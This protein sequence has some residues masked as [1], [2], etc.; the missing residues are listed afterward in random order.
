MK[1]LL[2]DC[3]LKMYK[4]RQQKKNTRFLGAQFSNS[5]N[6]QLLQYVGRES[7]EWMC[8]LP[9]MPRPPFHNLK[10][11]AHAQWPDYFLTVYGQ[12]GSS[13]SG[14]LFYN[15]C[16]GIGSNR[17]T[18]LLVGQRGPHM[19]AANQQDVKKNDAQISLFPAEIVPWNCTD[20]HTTILK[21]R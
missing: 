9:P 17:P 7:C 19:G 14:S 8:L 11:S 15:N 12:T 10:H 16:H 3:N 6:K 18:S 5:S 4:Y 21:K 20:Y 13:T 1:T 2:H